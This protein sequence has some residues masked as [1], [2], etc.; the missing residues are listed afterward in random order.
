MISKELIDILAC[1]ACDNRP[2]VHFSENRQYLVCDQCNRHY[3][4]RDDIPVMLVEEAVIPE[5]QDKAR[6]SG[7][8]G[9]DED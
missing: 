9:H 7:R 3:P 8:P 2:P 5:A 1:P 4:I 6:C